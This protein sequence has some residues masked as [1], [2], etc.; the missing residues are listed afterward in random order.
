MLLPG[1]GAIVERNEIRPYHV[2]DVDVRTGRIVGE[3]HVPQYRYAAPKHRGTC[4]PDGRRERPWADPS[5]RRV[6]HDADAD[7]G[8]LDVLIST[9]ART[10]I[11]RAKT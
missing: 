1:L 6:G 7:S 5:R 11:P 4:G 3:R 10:S 2:S 8:R 9:P